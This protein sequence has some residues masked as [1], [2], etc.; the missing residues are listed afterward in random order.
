MRQNTQNQQLLPKKR[1]RRRRKRKRV[2]RTFD[3]TRIGFLLKHETPIE[4]RLL[5]DITQWM[6]RQNPPADL[7]EAIGYSSSDEVFHKAKYWRALQDYR[8]NGLR[9]KI[10]RKP[11]VRVE[12]Y[13]VHIKMRKM[14]VR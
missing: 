14:G 9:P 12:L 10:Y 7:I 11:D 1:K 4:Y 8:K 3:E 13:Y 5:M 2:L 6:N